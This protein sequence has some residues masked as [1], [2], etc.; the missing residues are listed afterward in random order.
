M[1]FPILILETGDTEMRNTDL[2]CEVQTLTQIFSC[3]P[4]QNKSLLETFTGLRFVSAS[5]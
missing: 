1:R 5:K 2:D 4:R 3:T